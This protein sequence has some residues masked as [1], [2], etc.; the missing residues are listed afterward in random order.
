[1]NADMPSFISPD[2]PNFHFLG[3]G[4]LVGRACAVLF[5]RPVEMGNTFEKK[6]RVVLLH[7]GNIW[8]HWLLFHNAKNGAIVSANYTSIYCQACPAAARASCK[9][10]CASNLHAFFMK[11]LLCCR[12]ESVPNPPTEEPPQGIC[13]AP[14]WRGKPGFKA[15]FICG[16]Q[17][18]WR[19]HWDTND[20]ERL[21]CSTGS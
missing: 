9:Y 13:R 2:S 15:S 4:G 14:L 16:L 12:Q 11:R 21:S 20:T 17:L 5:P 8:L 1:M 7:P 19:S 18:L 10:C 6:A 3:G